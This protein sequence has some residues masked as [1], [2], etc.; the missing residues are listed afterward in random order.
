MFILDRGVTRRGFMKGVAVGAASLMAGS[1]LLGCAQKPE[2]KRPLKLGALV[3]LSGPSSEGGNRMKNA[4]EMAKEDINRGGGILGRPIDIIYYDTAGNAE[5]G[6]TGVKKLVEEDKVFA[7]VGV[8]T[9]GVGL[10][11]A[12]VVADYGIPLMVTVAASPKIPQL[13]RDNPERYKYMFRTGADVT[14]FTLNT[15]PFVT[16]IVGA[17]TYYYVGEEAIWSKA[18]DKVFENFLKDKG[19]EKLGS[20]FVPRGT[21]EFS[22]IIADIKSKDPDVVVASTVAAE[23]VPFAKQ[24]YD[25][26]IPV[27]FIATAGVLTFE[28]VVKEMGE[29]GNYVCFMSWCWDVPF[30]SK[31]REFYSRYREKYGYAPTGY[32]DVRSYDGLMVFAQAANKAGEPD[33]DKIKETLETNR[34]E[35]VAGY[36]EFD[37]G[38]QAKWGEGLLTG[39]IGEWYNGEA[40][41]L[42]PDNVKTGNLIKAPW[43]RV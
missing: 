33:Y 21:Q 17:K 32:E 41:I 4:F 30:T 35:G 43:W 19:V 40:T 24:Y 36:Y 38:H 16:D 23:G 12:D 15:A 22:S 28:D 29:K 39:V 11:I 10:A 25:A 8:Y 31:T 42:W 37:E 6:V 2:E 5:K 3:P 26:K 13:V 20:S 27:P 9:S 14:H 18:L 34:F 7:L 1:S